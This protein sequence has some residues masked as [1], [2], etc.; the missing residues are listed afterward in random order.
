MFAVYCGLLARLSELWE[1][2]VKFPQFP[3]FHS[4]I[5]FFGPFLK[6]PISHSGPSHKLLFNHQFSIS[7][8]SCGQKY[9]M[10]NRPA[11]ICLFYKHGTCF[12]CT[13]GTTATI[14]ATSQDNMHGEW[15]GP[16][17]AI[18]HW[19]ATPGAAAVLGLWNKHHVVGYGHMQTWDDLQWLQN[20]WIWK[21]T[22][23]KL[24]AELGPTLQV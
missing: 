16:A 24:F 21:A 17:A 1:C 12:F 14:T 6:I 20:F 19:P 15:K 10:Q 7:P 18:I 3:L 22:F 13:C 23:L 4:T 5:F 8:P 2:G 11:E 9:H